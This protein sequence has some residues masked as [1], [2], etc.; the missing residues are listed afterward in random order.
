MDIYL[1]IAN[2]LMHSGW[3][4]GGGE[5]TLE[6]EGKVQWGW[7]RQQTI[8]FTL[9]K[10]QVLFTIVNSTLCLLSRFR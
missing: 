10:L 8:Q 7:D 9:S 6:L 2:S 3:K 1:K 5:T 4:K